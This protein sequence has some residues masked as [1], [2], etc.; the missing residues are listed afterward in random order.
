M[1]DFLQQE[2][3]QGIS[4]D[5]I[6]E[7]LEID[8]LEETYAA[9][10]LIKEKG[11]ALDEVAIVVTGC[12]KTNT[13][14]REGKELNSSYFFGGDAFPFYLIYGGYTQYPYNVYCFKK[15]KV[16][17]FPKDELLSV[18]EKDTTFLINVLKFVSEYAS[19]AKLLLRVSQYFK[20]Q[21]RLAYWLLVINEHNHYANIPNSQE[22]LADIL[23]VNRSS[24]NQELKHLESLGII[25]LENKRITIIDR[26]Y[27]R[28]LI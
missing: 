8:Y 4:E 24:L 17:W 23:M 28:T 20:V 19:Y 12:L 25:N 3:F 18:V 11:E 15:S 10:E 22:V 9:N 14:T 16:V 21:E 26:E 1:K 27:L 6:Q 2:I 5:V 7:I 13:F